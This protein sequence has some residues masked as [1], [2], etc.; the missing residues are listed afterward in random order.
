MELLNIIKVLIQ[1]LNRMIL[2]R[3]VI[4]MLNGNGEEE[5]FASSE[6][7]KQVPEA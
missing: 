2:G 7:I 1:R 5:S 3:S 6:P 4:H